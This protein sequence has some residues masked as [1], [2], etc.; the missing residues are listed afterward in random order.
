MDIVR[1]G[2]TLVLAGEFDVRS[3]GDVRRELYAQ[4]ADHGADIVVDLSRVEAVDLTALK[5]LAVASRVASRRGGHLRLRG[6]GPHVMRMLHMTRLIRLVE[7][8]RTPV[9]A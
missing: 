1:D 5:V 3:T 2:P 4:L 8:E 6:C 7:V 9:P